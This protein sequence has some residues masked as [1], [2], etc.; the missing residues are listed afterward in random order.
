MFAMNLFQCGGTLDEVMG[1]VSDRALVLGLESLLAQVLAK[2]FLL[3]S[4]V[5][6]KEKPFGTVMG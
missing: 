3:L 5:L 2:E 1:L 4:E 6:V